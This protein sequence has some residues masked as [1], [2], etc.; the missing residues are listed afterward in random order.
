MKIALALVSALTLNVSSPASHSNFKCTLSKDKGDV[1]AQGKDLVIEAGQNVQS[2]LVVHGNLLIRKGA[3]VKDAVAFEGSV[4]L[5]PGAVVKGSALAFGGNVHAQGDARIGKDA[6]ALGGQLDV[7]P[8]VA[9]AGDRVSLSVDLG[10]S[11]LAQSLIEG[12]LG[13]AQQCRIV[14]ADAKAEN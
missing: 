7:A 11:A 5:E 12:F 8:T 6:V 1:L 9:V 4:T 10:G 14:E 13:A 3:V 2:A